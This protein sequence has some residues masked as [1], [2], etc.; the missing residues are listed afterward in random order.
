[1]ANF[2]F[3]IDRLALK[4][5]CPEFPKN[6]IK[7]K[8]KTMNAIDGTVTHGPKSRGTL[9]EH[10]E[11]SEYIPMQIKSMAFREFLNDKDR[12]LNE[13]WLISKKKETFTVDPKDPTRRSSLMPMY[14]PHFHFQ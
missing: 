13:Q 12:R 14:C 7:N 1:V 3:S 10:S 11:N 6:L 8:K 4:K 2:C 5:F 9:T